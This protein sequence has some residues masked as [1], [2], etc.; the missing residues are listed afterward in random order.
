M[1][2]Y[3]PLDG[4]GKAESRVTAQGSAPVDGIQGLHEL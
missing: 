3:G 2:G 1:R 4:E